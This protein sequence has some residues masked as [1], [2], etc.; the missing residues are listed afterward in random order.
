M[1]FARVQ[2]GKSKS[3]PPDR[4]LRKQPDGYDSV[5]GNTNGSDVFMIYRNKKAYPEYLI[6]YKWNWFHL[7]LNYFFLSKKLL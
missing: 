7:C 2:V 4:N 6:T 3:L 1:F 5:H